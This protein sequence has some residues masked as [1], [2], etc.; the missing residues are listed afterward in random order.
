M[1]RNIK[2][3]KSKIT[4][5][6]NDNLYQIKNHKNKLYQSASTIGNYILLNSKKKN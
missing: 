4:K 1:L 5:L 2:L 6:N 3:I